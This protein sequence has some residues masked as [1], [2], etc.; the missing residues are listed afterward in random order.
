LNVLARGTIALGVWPHLTLKIDGK[1]ADGISVTTNNLAWFT[2]A[3][4]LTPG[5]HEL[6]LHFD[7]DAYNPPEDRN[8]FLDEVR[9]GQE[10]EDN[11]VKLLT[12]PGV[13]AQVQRG[14]GWIVLDEV[15]WETETRNSVKAARHASALL[16]GMGAQM[17]L[18]WSL[19]TEAE[20]MR[21]VN[22]NAYTAG[23]GLARLNSGGRIETTNYFTTAGWYTF[24]IVAGGTAAAGVLPQIGITIDGVTRTNFFC[25]TTN[26][27]SYTVT[28][29]VTAGVHLVGLAFLNDFYAPPEDRNAHLDRM[30]ITPEGALR[31]TVLEADAA[32]KRLTL[33]WPARV[34]RNYEVQVAP[35][36]ASESWQGAA[37]ISNT[38]TSASWTDSG[39][40]G[41][42][43]L[44]AANSNRFYRLRQ[45]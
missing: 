25:A 26:L 41:G 29:Q 20:D 42:P 45:L 2:L 4:D 13:V 28:I 40:L 14:A 9:W 24:E 39:Q 34:G 11:P 16:T 1:A 18:P 3:T 44:T 6:S 38:G 36:L 22:V 30:S 15:Q 43:P 33:Q 32:E 17:R 31:L 21:N 8:L 7:N 37:T 23:G 19:R 27:T 10:P 5:S 35:N 12:G